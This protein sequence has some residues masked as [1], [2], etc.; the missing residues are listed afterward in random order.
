MTISSNV[1]LGKMFNFLEFDFFFYLYKNGII[2]S[3]SG[4]CCET[5]LTRVLCCVLWLS[6]VLQI[7]LPPGMDTTCQVARCSPGC[8]ACDAAPCSCKCETADDGEHPLV[9]A[10]NKGSLDGMSLSE[11]APIPDLAVSSI[12]GGI[13]WADDLSLSLILH[14]EEK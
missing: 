12:W 2:I 14:M 8:S 5:Y 11:L 9:S 7:R 6:S 3:F 4:N 10:T 1:S 13:L